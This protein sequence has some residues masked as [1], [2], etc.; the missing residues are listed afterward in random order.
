MFNTMIK[1]LVFAALLLG[2]Y[3]IMASHDQIIE[4]EI[5]GLT[6]SFCVYGLQKN[7]EKHVEI[8]TAEISLKQNK[9]RIHLTPGAT[10]TEEKLKEIIKNAGFASGMAQH[11]GRKEHPCENVAC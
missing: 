1:H 8:E 7:L 9:A 3:S 10:V 5:S 4:I 6:C 2:S 11:Y